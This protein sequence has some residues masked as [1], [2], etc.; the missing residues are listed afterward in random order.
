[1]LDPRWCCNKKT[2]IIDARDTEVGYRRRRKC[3]ICSCRFTTIERRVS[4]IEKLDSLNEDQKV[5]LNLLFKSFGM[6]KDYFD[7]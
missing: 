3:L 1:M 7:V 5:F 2:K 6:E 4:E